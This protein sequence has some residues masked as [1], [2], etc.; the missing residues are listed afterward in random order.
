MSAF[1][2][3]IHSL[4]GSIALL[5]GPPLDVLTF[6]QPA[7][8]QARFVFFKRSSALSEILGRRISELRWVAR[9]QAHPTIPLA[10][11]QEV[12]K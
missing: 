10:P 4:M 5:P 11:S 1:L 6:E 9:K 12:I 7:W 3:R 8:L 2:G